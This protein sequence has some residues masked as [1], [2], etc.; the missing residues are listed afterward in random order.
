MFKEAKKIISLFEQSVAKL[1]LHCVS[2]LPLPLGINKTI[3]V[4]KG[5]KSTFIVDHKLYELPVYGIFSTFTKGYLETVIDILLDK[6]LLEII[7]V[8][9]YDNL[10]IL[11]LT[12][13]GQDFL[14]NQV[15]VETPFAEELRNKEI[16]LLSNEEQELFHEMRKLRR[17]IAIEN[18]IPPL[19]YNS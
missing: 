12:P 7:M 3:G 4:M 18:E 6:G 2:T 1:V 13:K 9:K 14:N 15:I 10:P 11:S 17:K 5:V 16:I 8:S 19:Y